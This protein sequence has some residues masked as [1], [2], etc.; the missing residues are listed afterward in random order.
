ASPVSISQQDIREFQLA[1]A[2]ISA[3]LQILLN[4]LGKKHEDIDSIY[5]AGGFGNFINLDHVIKLGMLEF[6]A[7]KIK[8]LG[9]SALIGAKMMLFMDDKEINEIISLS[10][11]VSLES[12]MDFQN[13]Y[14][15][16]MFFF[17]NTS[18]L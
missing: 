13:V 9:N 4:K 7:G 16:K 18:T 10:E 12:D 6:P 8:K 17:D 2:A 1:K 5:I 11:H 3:G 14:V 15:D